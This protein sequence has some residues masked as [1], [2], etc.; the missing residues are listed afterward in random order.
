MSSDFYGF[1]EVVDM[2]VVVGIDSKYILCIELSNLNIII[3]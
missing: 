1:I 3:Y 2:R